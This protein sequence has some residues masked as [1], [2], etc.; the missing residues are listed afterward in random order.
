M[1]EIRLRTIAP[2]DRE[3]V[4]A[5]EA[6]STPRLRYLPAVFES[7]RADPDGDFFLAEVD[8]EVVACAKYTPLPNDSIW[9]ETLRVIPARQGRG[10]GKAL[11]R[12]YL[13]KAAAQRARTLRMY[14]GITNAVSKGLAEHFGFTLE[15]TFLGFTQEC[16]AIA[17]PTRAARL[18]PLHDPAEAAALLMPQLDAWRNFL[19]MNRTFYAAT[20]GLCAEFA[21]QG[22]VYA[23]EAGNLVVFG[24]RFSPEIALHLACYAGDA[25]ACI[26][27]AQGE[28]LR[29]GTERI[30][31]ILPIEAERQHAELRAHGF[32]DD[33][34]PYI[35]MRRDLE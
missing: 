20:P 34:S 19:V 22:F 31:V 16:G 7:F 33:P 28:A 8:G 12:R 15:Q 10:I 17:P 2:A 1:S 4:L 24:A 5:V 27:F 9:L 32:K 6:L 18:Q 13:A 25:A 23:D 29:R 11:Y 14:T 3:A 35:V 30:H 26:Q 21:R